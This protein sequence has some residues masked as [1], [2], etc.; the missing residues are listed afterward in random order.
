M[1]K[2]LRRIVEIGNTHGNKPGQ[3][4]LVLRLPVGRIRPHLAG[5]TFK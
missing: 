1:P 2:S 5:A 3:I 4:L